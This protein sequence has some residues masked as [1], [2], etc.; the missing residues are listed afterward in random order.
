M[1]W[2]GKK[3]EENKTY[4]PAES[5]HLHEVH[6][7]VE[8]RNVWNMHNLGIAFWIFVLFTAIGIASGALNLDVNEKVILWTILVIVYAVILF[9]LLEPSRVKRIERKETRTIEKEVPVVKE[10]VK[11]VPVVKEV[12]KPVIREVVKEVE[13]PVYYPVKSTKLNIPK[14]DYVASRL[15]QTYHKSNCRLGKSIKKMY[16]EH[17]NDTGIFQRKGYRPCKSCITKEVKV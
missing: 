5:N 17:S 4:S 16:K 8:E 11:E 14:Y 9:F 12:E 7:N 3:E 1:S 10:I 6:E 15:T 13:K 2:F